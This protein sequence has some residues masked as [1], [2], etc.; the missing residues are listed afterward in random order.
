MPTVLGE[1]R[2]GHITSVYF[3]MG[4]RELFLKCVR[5]L[6]RVLRRMRSPVAVLK[7]GSCV[8]QSYVLLDNCFENP[9][10]QMNPCMKISFSQIKHWPYPWSIMCMYS[11]YTPSVGVVGLAEYVCTHSFFNFYKV[12]SKLRSRGRWVGVPSC[13]QSCLWIE[14]PAGSSVWCKTLMTSS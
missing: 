7:L 1:L 6:C 5:Q 2:C 11:V 10:S 3:G 9:F 12:R 4:W 8:D 14:S 13:T